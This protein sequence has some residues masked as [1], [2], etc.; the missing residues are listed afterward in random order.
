MRGRRRGKGRGGRRRVLQ[1]DGE[2]PANDG[3]VHGVYRHGEERAVFAVRRI[4]GRSGCVPTGVDRRSG[5]WQR[6]DAFQP[7]HVLRERPGAE[8]GGGGNGDDGPGYAGCGA[9]RGP[10]LGGV[11]H[12]WGRGDLARGGLQCPTAESGVG[13]HP[14][15]APGGCLPPVPQARRRRVLHG[16]R[17]DRA[18]GI[19][20]VQPVVRPDHG[21]AHDRGDAVD[22]ALLR[23]GDRGEPHPHTPWVCGAVV[24]DAARDG[25]ERFGL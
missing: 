16:R 20:R 11:D 22:E 4:R 6:C 17:L 1:R 2:Q 12:V 19:G 8:A 21:G 10:L 5:H 18:A 23:D 13:F 25:V 7:E 9:E 24:R 14:P 3:G 15:H